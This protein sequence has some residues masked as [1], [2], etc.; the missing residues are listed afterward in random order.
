MSASTAE[1][2][3]KLL[4]L[5]EDK[6]FEENEKI[7]K[8]LLK[9]QKIDTAIMYNGKVDSYLNPSLILKQKLTK[10]DVEEIKRLHVIRL[11]LFDYMMKPE[12][13]EDIALLRECVKGMELIEYAMQKAWKFDKDRTK[14]SWW[15]RVPNCL[16]PKM[17]NSERFGTKDR[18]INTKCPCHG[19][20]H[21]V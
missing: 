17:D 13:K 15:Y 5:A 8:A 7:S 1:S 10:E 18:I 4:D 20:I 9:D 2:F 11:E 12:V 6:L 3:L 21:G 19:E 14:H 16:C